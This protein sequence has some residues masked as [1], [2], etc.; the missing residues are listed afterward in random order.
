MT[1][2]PDSG[3][4]PEPIFVR[5]AH[6]QAAFGISVSSIYRKAQAGSIKI[7]KCDGGSFL[8]TSEM[9]QY[10]ERESKNKEA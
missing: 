8:K 10:I 4:K 1:A 5:V 9:K 3:F 7:H 2:K 6:S